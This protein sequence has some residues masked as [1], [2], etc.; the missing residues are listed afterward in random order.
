M[1]RKSKK[2]KADVFDLTFFDSAH[3]KTKIKDTIRVFE[4]IPIEQ[5]GSSY[6]IKARQRTG[7]EKNF[8]LKMPDPVD[9]TSRDALRDRFVREWKRGSELNELVKAIRGSVSGK[10]ELKFHLPELV[11]AGIIRAVN[12]K[13][14]H[15]FCGLPFIIYE[16]VDGVQLDTVLEAG[17]RKNRKA[18]G[19]FDTSTTSAKQLRAKWF[20]FAHGLTNVVRRLHNH[21][22][23]HAYIVPRNILIRFN[24][25]IPSSCT[26]AGFGY[27]AL[28]IE[29]SVE[30]LKKIPSDEPFQSP[31]FS[32]RR[33]LDALWH[34]SDIYSIGAVLLCLAIGQTGNS[35]SLN[36]VLTVSTTV[37][38]LKRRVR[39][40]L[41]DAQDRLKEAK[42]PS[43]KRLM[44]ILENENV[45]KIIDNCLRHD[46]DDRIETAE[47][48]IEA[49][50]IADTQPIADSQSRSKVGPFFSAV[51]TQKGQELRAFAARLK[52]WHHFELLGSRT[53]IIEG[54]CRMLGSLQPNAIYCTITL[55]SYWTSE[56][57]G[58]DGRF[59]A[60]NKHVV[61]RG[62][63][64]QRIF[65]V[66]GP[67]HTLSDTE[68]IILR[69]QQEAAE[70]LSRQ[71][72]L[73]FNVK[74]QLVDPSTVHGFE[75][76][77]NS[78][79]FVAW[80]KHYLEKLQTANASPALGQFLCL[81]F[82][83]R[84]DER[85]RYGKSVIEREI[86]KV[87]IWDP[88]RG[89]VYSQ[90]LKEEVMR[91]TQGW[92]QASTLSLEQY[93]GEGSIL[94]LEQLLTRGRP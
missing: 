51:L 6:R 87:R 30:P 90:K 66:S 18:D 57:L 5:F 41:N 83:S 2:P 84:G 53:R 73:N 21:G 29:E 7:P 56:N 28:S 12:K 24:K 31:E 82:I 17:L 19:N 45:S 8:F 34:P 67:Y 43:S 40:A 81:N 3:A 20:E 94:T 9:P 48:L 52:K 78:V 35:D 11:G 46:P 74:V 64:I 70:E 75:R 22:F 91:F 65:L 44:E 42:D 47:D 79:A 39:L 63:E 68:Q 71:G 62:V 80:K 4:R 50:D 54:L 38:D 37:D 69:S 86:K 32:S 85:N 15:P 14:S 72:H 26:L 61:R 76:Q 33:P 89:P 16:W 36:D 93:I 59:L 92:N 1:N 58:P 49:I 27:S 13:T 60:M 10:S 55:P 88:C 23:L 77:G 25:D